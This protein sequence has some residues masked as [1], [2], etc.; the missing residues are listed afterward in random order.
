MD[1]YKLQEDIRRMAKKGNI[2]LG[3]SELIEILNQ[4]VGLLFRMNAKQIERESGRRLSGIF[5]ATLMLMDQYKLDPLDEINQ[6][7]NFGF[8]YPEKLFS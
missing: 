4:E 2:N 1:L 7:I 6:R 3:S 8:S 5:I